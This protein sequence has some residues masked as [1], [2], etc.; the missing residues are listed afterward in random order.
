MRRRLLAAA[1]ALAADGT[2]PPGVDAPEVYQ[3]RSGGVVLQADADWMEAT[4][5]L[6]K[7]GVEHPDLDPALAGGA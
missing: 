1:R 7:A 6:R 4:T 3:Q 2:V 5:E